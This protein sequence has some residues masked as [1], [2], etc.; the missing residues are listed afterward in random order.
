MSLANYA[1]ISHLKLSFIKLP[2]MLSLIH[3]LL[4]KTSTY[5][6]TQQTLC[7][8]FICNGKRSSCVKI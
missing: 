5:D 1:V 6:K 4:K 3:V 8:T 7:M 2:F